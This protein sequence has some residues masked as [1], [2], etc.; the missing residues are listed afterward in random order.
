M[1]SDLFRVA[2]EA[3]SDAILK[4][5]SSEGHLMNISHRLA[6]NT[7]H[8]RYELNVVG[9]YNYMYTIQCG[10]LESEVLVL[11]LVE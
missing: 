11:C 5:Y 6:A 10:K 2:A 1:L 3:E 7:P 9:A 4:L 8:T